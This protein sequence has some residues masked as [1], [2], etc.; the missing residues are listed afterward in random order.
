MKVAKNTYE[1]LL[2]CGKLIERANER[3]YEKYACMYDMEMN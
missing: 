3:K 2:Q 1:L